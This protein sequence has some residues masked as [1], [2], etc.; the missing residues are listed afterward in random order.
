MTCTRPT[1][2]VRTAHEPGQRTGVGGPAT[3][4]A[5]LDDAMSSIAARSPKAG[6]TGG[7]GSAAAP[8]PRGPADRCFFCGPT[9][10]ERQGGAAAVSQTPWGCGGHDSISRHRSTPAGSSWR[11]VFRARREPSCPCPRGVLA[12]GSPCLSW[13]SFSWASFSWGV[14]RPQAA[15]RS[16]PRRRCGG[17][18][19]PCCARPPC[20]W[21]HMWP[22]ESELKQQRRHLTTPPNPGQVTMPPGTRCNATAIFPR[23]IRSGMP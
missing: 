7:S 23:K 6:T 8:P 4:S 22:L 5:A 17:V 16:T 2:P 11:R 9:S 18:A 14:A 12:A 20:Q 3:A 1:L 19:A 13:A 15:A 10:N 21:P